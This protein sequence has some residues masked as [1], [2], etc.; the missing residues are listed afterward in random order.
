LKQSGYVWLEGFSLMIKS[1]QFASILLTTTLLMK[2][3]HSSLIRREWKCQYVNKYTRHSLWGNV[4]KDRPY[5]FKICSASA[6]SVILRLV[7]A[8]VVV[9]SCKI[10][11]RQ[12][13]YSVSGL[14][15]LSVFLLFCFCCCCFSFWTCYFFLLMLNTNSK[16]Y[17]VT[18]PNFVFS[19]WVTDLFPF[20]W[21][22]FFFLFQF[23][24]E[25]EGN[26]YLHCWSCYTRL[27]ICLLPEG[28]EF[29]HIF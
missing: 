20:L 4:K 1:T 7:F 16:C 2:Q 27:S 9:G 3:A 6:F 21:C 23:P 10:A 25:T 29:F 26:I 8:W 28:F 12:R 18:L 17:F 5:S 13:Y 19:F 11:G 14:W 22:G 15:T 24:I